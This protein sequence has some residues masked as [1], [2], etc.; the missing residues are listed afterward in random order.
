VPNPNFRVFALRAADRLPLL[1]VVLNRALG[2]LSQ[3]DD[4]SVRDLSAVIEE[5]VVITGSLLSIANSALY[6]GN[7]RVASVRPAIVRLGLRKTRNVLLGLTVS[8]C[9]TTV[10]AP[11]LW[12]SIRFNAHSLAV[13]TL[14]D[15]IVQSAPAENAEWAFM[16]GLLHDI[17]LPLIVV[18]LPEQFRAIAMQA[19]GEVNLVEREREVLGFT[20]FDL[21]A[22]MLARWNCP[23]MV[24]EATRFGDTMELPSERPLS[25]AA[26]VKTA[27]LLADASG[28][29]TF[30]SSE[31]DSLVTQL[32]EALEIP[33]P[34]H[35]IAKFKAEFDSVQP[36]AA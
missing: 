34:L 33:D 22:E 9:F 1:S 27:S 19:G 29:S 20:H 18:G 23:P 12:S 2:L 6:S 21:G 10:R 13:A 3:G 30:D 31:D 28:I 8:R 32:L 11:G 16:A 17:G 36:C 25:L 35:F 24:Q 4:V 7:S 26:V 5:D 15:L 14:S